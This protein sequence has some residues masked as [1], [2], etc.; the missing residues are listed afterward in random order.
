MDGLL[1][2]SYIA[3]IVYHIADFI[4]DW[5][6]WYHFKDSNPD[7]GTILTVT[8]LCGTIFKSWFLYR[9]FKTLRVNSSTA[10]LPE[11]NFPWPEGVV[12]LI[13]AVLGGDI[14]SSKFRTG[15]CLDAMNLDFAYCCCCG[16][17]MQCVFVLKNLCG[18]HGKRDNYYCQDDK[19]VNCLGL[20]LSLISALIGVASISDAQELQS[21]WHSWNIWIDYMNN[22]DLFLCYFVFL[23]NYINDRLIEQIIYWLF[24]ILND[25]NIQVRLLNI[26]E[27]L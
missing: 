13:Q 20:V 17:V 2:L 21:C 24:I 26:T 9:L 16:A 27:N 6:C 8:C 19:L 4:C 7:R 23:I 14:I 3:L 1:V 12:N 5:N 15:S 18:Y 22:G 10:I 11:L 25:S